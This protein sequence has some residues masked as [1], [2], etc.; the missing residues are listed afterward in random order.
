MRTARR[1]DPS[2]AAHG[3]HRRRARVYGVAYEPGLTWRLLFRDDGPLCWLCGERVDPADKKPS[4]GSW[5]IG[6]R[7]PTVD[8]V[9]PMARKGPHVRANIRLAHMGCNS[10]R[11]TSDGPKPGQLSLV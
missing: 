7:Y 8:H 6:K 9:I 3:D 5:A 1:I 4:G 10:E 2:Y 11:H